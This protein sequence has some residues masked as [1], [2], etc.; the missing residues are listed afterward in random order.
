MRFERI[1]YIGHAYSRMKERY[2]AHADVLEA[3]NNPYT[4]FPGNKPGRNVAQGV[5]QDERRIRVVYVE[6]TEEALDATVLT[7]IDLEEEE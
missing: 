5:A 3:L 2:I 6:S 7:V 4:T 1:Q